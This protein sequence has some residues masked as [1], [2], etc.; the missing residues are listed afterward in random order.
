MVNK[1]LNK[2]LKDNKDKSV[3]GLSEFLGVSQQLAEYYVKKRDIFK[4]PLNL[5]HQISEYMEV[6][7]TDIIDKQ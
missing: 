3:T 5:G 4:T 6:P 2:L 7:I 1:K